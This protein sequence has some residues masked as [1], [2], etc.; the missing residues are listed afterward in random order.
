MSNSTNGLAKSGEWQQQFYVSAAGEQQG[1]FSIEQIVERVKAKTLD[2][3]DYLFDETQQDWV[4]LMAHSRL[5]ESLKALKPATPPAAATPL[6]SKATAFDKSRTGADVAEWFVLKGE[7]KFGPFAYSELIKMLQD[8]SVFE[9][10][11]VWHLGLKAWERIATLAEFSPEKIRDFRTTTEGPI[12]EVF[13]RRRHARAQHGA[14][15]LVHD[16]RA[17]YK[18]RSI[19]V[20]AG[21]AGIVI[22]NAILQPGEMLYLHFKPAGNTPPFNATCEIISKSYVNASDKSAPVRYG[23]KFTKIESQTQQILNEFALKTAA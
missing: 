16:N 14:S 12:N 2:A 19:E 4:M 23:V 13:F 5:S 3:S 9:F 8:K 11:Y 15:I 10:D 21:G 17:V 1:P 20:S 18:G 6:A 7:S 22:E